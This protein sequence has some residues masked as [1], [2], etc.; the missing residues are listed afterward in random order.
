MKL[1][2]DKQ[3]NRRGLKNSRVAVLGAARSGIAVSGLL[4]DA[5]A[6]VLLSDLKSFDLLPEAARNLQQKGVEIESGGHTGRV[7]ENDLICISPGLPLDI[8]ILQQAKRKSIPIVGEIELASWFCDAPIYA[9]TGSN[10]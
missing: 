10:G 4:L 7:L 5:G 1:S 2:A 3:R 9:I 8:P 6:S